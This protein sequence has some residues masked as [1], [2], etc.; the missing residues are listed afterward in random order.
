MKPTATATDRWYPSA[1]TN[2]NPPTKE[3]GRQSSTSIT[4]PIW[5][6]CTYSTK[7]TSIK[8]KGMIHLI[9]FSACCRFRYCPD[10]V[11]A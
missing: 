6:K 10:Q 11:M 4:L 9:R 2:Q 3:N 1:Y 7:T 5:R 8:V